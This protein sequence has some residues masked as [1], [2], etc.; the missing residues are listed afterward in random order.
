VVKKFVNLVSTRCWPVQPG[1]D[2][3]GSDANGGAADF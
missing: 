2:H 3:K 1:A